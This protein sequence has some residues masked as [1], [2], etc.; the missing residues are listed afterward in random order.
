MKD[1]RAELRNSHII[2]ASRYEFNIPQL[3]LKHFHEPFKLVLS[4]GG[5]AMDA[6]PP[7]TNEGSANEKAAASVSDS[8]SADASSAG[9]L[10][11]RD[12]RSIHVAVTIEV[13][14]LTTVQKVWPCHLMFDQL[15]D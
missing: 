15:N 3:Q 6:N 1:V 10:C 13:R 2:T 4:I 9:L 5:S 8:S 11:F 12:C 7:L 14:V